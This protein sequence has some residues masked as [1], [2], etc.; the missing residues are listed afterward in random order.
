MANAPLQPQ[1]P[2][3]ALDFSQ[4]AS[5]LRARGHRTANAPAKA[6]LGPRASYSRAAWHPIRIC[7]CGYR[8]TCNAAQYRTAACPRGNA[9][10]HARRSLGVFPARRPGG[11]SPGLAWINI[12]GDGGKLTLASARACACKCGYHRYADAR[13]R[14]QHPRIKPA[15]CAFV[16]AAAVRWPRA[17]PRKRR[18]AHAKTQRRPELPAE[19]RL[20]VHVRATAPPKQTDHSFNHDCTVL[21]SMYSCYHECIH[22]SYRRRA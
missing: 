10:W 9:N 15:A 19:L 1:L 8:R 20:R 12:G 16:G 11:P 5:W 3:P 13:P 7:A 6:H 17:Q 2:W 14:V 4:H 22:V 18:A 21:A